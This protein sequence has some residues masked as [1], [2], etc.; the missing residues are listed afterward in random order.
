MTKETKKCEIISEELLFWDNAVMISWIL[1]ERNA[2]EHYGIRW[3]YHCK[4]GERIKR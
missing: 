4:Y 1:F 3:N 2:G